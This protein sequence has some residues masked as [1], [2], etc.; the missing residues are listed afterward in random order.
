MKIDALRNEKDLID[1][2]SIRRTEMKKT[3][4]TQN[5]NKSDNNNGKVWS[6]YGF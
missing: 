1:L 2:N 3:P 5:N 6:C 4:L